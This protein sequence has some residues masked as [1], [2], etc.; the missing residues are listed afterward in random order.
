MTVSR[1]TLVRPARALRGAVRVPPD[2]SISHRYALLAALADGPTTL[3]GYSTGA[4]CQSTLG[5]LAG[6]G[7][8]VTRATT[9]RGQQVRIEGRPRGFAAPSRPLDC[10]N[11][12][13]TMRLVAGLVASQPF[14]SVLMGDA[15]LS[16][17][18]MRRVMAPL[19][20]MGA[21]LEAEDGGRPPLRITGRRLT[22]ITH[23]PEV[24]S[25]QIKSAVLLAG[26]RASGTTTI[27]EAAQTRDHT[28][29]ALTAFGVAVTST[30][31]GHISVDGGARLSGGLTFGVPGDPSATAFLAV[32]AAGLAGSQVDIEDVGLNPTR[33][34]LFDVLRRAGADVTIE[35]TGL[36]HGE[37]VGRVRVA[38]GA[39]LDVVVTPGEVPLLIDELPALAA[40]A[41]FG[42]SI[43][44]TGAQELRVKESDRISALVA[45]LR[46]MGADVDE[47]PDGFAV[48]GSRQLTG[49]SVDA[50]HDHRLAMSFAVAALG[51]SHP[52]EIAGAEVAA[53]SFPG[54]FELID[55]LRA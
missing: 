29:R 25:A 32:A 33:T 5:V 51:G 22:G 10:G 15:S 6:L 54:F 52:T 16:S 38:T 36:W 19:T 41:T 40:L 27:I 11:S 4:D 53:V 3:E 23:T 13:T 20:V 42:G 37:P 12:G 1:A 39:K 21:D 55:G 48:R 31:G 43:V 30:A 18:P 2:K 47:F 50:R 35:Q 46:A 34:A 44:V 17:R 9:P 24:P 49:G 45:G 26:L 8:V 14:S 7:V 28:E